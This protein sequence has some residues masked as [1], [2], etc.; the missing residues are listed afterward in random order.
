MGTSTRLWAGSKARAGR[1]GKASTGLR[2]L[3]EITDGARR[4]GARE[5]VGEPGM[6]PV[7]AADCAE[8][9][10]PFANAGS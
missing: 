5:H 6:L 4:R 8:R 1:Q 3:D 9:P 2:V 7:L 10:A